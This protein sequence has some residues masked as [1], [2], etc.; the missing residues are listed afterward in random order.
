MTADRDAINWGGRAATYQHV[1][2]DDTD[3]EHQTT[4]TKTPPSRRVGIR[5]GLHRADDEGRWRDGRHSLKE[6][7]FELTINRQHQRCSIPRRVVTSAGRLPRLAS[8]WVEPCGLC[9]ALES[10]PAIPRCDRLCRA[11]D[12]PAG[13]TSSVGREV[14]RPG[15]LHGTRRSGDIVHQYN[16]GRL[17]KSTSICRRRRHCL[18]GS[19]GI[20]AQCAKRPTSSLTHALV[21]C[22][23]K[24]TI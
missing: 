1:S 17:L 3:V 13:P 23:V 18:F 2:F 21:L 9:T 11:A 20:A 8:R 6:N 15:R 16:V 14:G 19:A 10:S 7:V 4:Y 5:R 22:N 24:R 12:A